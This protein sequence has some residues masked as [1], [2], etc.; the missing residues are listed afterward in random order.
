VVIAFLNAVAQCGLVAWTFFEFQD[1]SHQILLFG[2]GASPEDLRAQI[3]ARAKDRGVPITPADL[4]VH[5]EGV[6]TVAVATYTQPI[7]VFPRFVY[8]VP[9]SFTVDA[10]SYE[11]PH[12]ELRGGAQA[13]TKAR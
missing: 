4:T 1:A 7:E 13:K 5:R 3:L 9:L 2:A 11:N 6:R 8:P 12:R 10:L